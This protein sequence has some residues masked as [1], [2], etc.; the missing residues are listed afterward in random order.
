M[1]RLPELKNFKAVSAPAEPE[2]RWWTRIFGY[3]VVC[4]AGV[5]LGVGWALFQF[6]G[7]H[8]DDRLQRAKILSD[9]AA[10]NRMLDRHMVIAGT[11]GLVLTACF[12]IAYEVTLKRDDK[13]V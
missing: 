8:P 3:V 13:K 12:C 2:D 6:S 10:Y 4:T 5:A 11:V 1:K 9:T 7:I